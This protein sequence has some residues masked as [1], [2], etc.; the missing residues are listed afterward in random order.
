MRHAAAAAA[1][2]SA[3]ARSSAAAEKKTTTTRANKMTTTHGKQTW[4]SAEFTDHTGR[5]VRE[6]RVKKVCTWPA[7]CATPQTGRAG[8]LAH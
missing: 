3:A 4:A 5:D 8:Y 1:A 7:G 6:P 2:Q